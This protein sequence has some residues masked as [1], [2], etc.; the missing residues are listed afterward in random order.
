LKKKVGTLGLWAARKNPF[1]AAKKR[2]R[3]AK[4]AEALA[5]NSTG[6]HSR[7]L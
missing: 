6:G 2:A 3:K 5:G 7:Q 4:M 1:G